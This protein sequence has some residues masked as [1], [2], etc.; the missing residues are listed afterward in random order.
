MVFLSHT[1]NGRSHCHSTA[2]QFKQIQFVPLVLPFVAC[3]NGSARTRRWIGRHGRLDGTFATY[4]CYAMSSFAPYLLYHFI[5]SSAGLEFRFRDFSEWSF[6]SWRT[7]ADLKFIFFFCSIVINFARHLLRASETLEQDIRRKSEHLFAFQT[8]L[9]F[10]NFCEKIRGI[11]V[12]FRME[13]CRN[14]T[15][16]YRISDEFSSSFLFTQTKQEKM[17]RNVIAKKKKRKE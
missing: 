5:V 15:S 10:L 16:S 8:N 13:D 12:I 1:Q 14:C 11:V 9:F 3:M 6:R 2:I 7:D 17:Q 4:K